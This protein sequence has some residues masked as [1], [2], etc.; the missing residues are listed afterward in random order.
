MIGGKAG[1]AAVSGKPAASPGRSKRQL[2]RRSLDEP[3]LCTLRRTGRGEDRL[4]RQIVRATAEKVLRSDDLIADEKEP[5]ASLLR[6]NPAFRNP[7]VLRCDSAHETKT[8]FTTHT[9]YTCKRPA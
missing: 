6:A 4:T 8:L 5:P 3:Q 2:N 7:P 1:S 9:A